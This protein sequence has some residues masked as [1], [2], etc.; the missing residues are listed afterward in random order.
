MSHKITHEQVNENK[1][2]EHEL[3][4]IFVLWYEI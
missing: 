2:N 3:E 4:E 1:R